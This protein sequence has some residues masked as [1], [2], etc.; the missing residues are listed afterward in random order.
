VRDEAREQLREVRAVLGREHG[1]GDGETLGTVNYLGEVSG[2][3][4]NPYGEASSPLNVDRARMSVDASVVGGELVVDV[5]IRRDAAPAEDAAAFTET[6]RDALTGYADRSERTGLRPVPADYGLDTVTLAQLDALLGD[7]RA[8][9]V[10]P[11]SPLQEGML[12]E[13]MRGAG[14][15]VVQVEYAFAAAT[16]ADRL[17]RAF[18]E[19]SART[20]ALRSVF[21]WDAGTAP[22]QL[23]L[24][25]TGVEFRHSDHRA[26]SEE[27]RRAALERR[28]AEQHARPFDLRRGPLFRCDAFTHADDAHVLVFTHHHAVLDGWSLSELC[29]RF[30]AIHDALA[31]GAPMPDGETDG[32]PIPTHGAHARL[33]AE[34][35]SG[36]F[37]AYWSRLL[38]GHEGGAEITGI[39]AGGTGTG[40]LAAASATGLATRLQAAFSARGATL[41]HVAEAAWGLVLSRLTGT[42]DVVFGKVVSGRDVALPGV[43]RTVGLFI[44]TVPARV[45]LDP[46]AT[47]AGLVDAVREQAV[48]TAEHDHGSLARIQSIAGVEDLVRCVFAVENYHVAEDAVLEFRCAREATNYPLTVTVERVG[49]EVEV[50]VLHDR[51]VLGAGD[52][53]RIAGRFLAVLE[54]FAGDAERPLSEVSGFLAGERERV[55]DVFDPSRVGYPRDGW[56]GGVFA[57]VA[58]EHADRVALVHGGE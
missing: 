37:D 44:N 25:D 42:P 48:A 26:L 13:H 51:A 14:D 23:V 43:E 28:C 24:P 3:G 8:D 20:P 29:R 16:D 7:T 40:R 52:A 39:E 56:I 11:L 34:R 45:R 2:P 10:H 35:G 58:A 38:D 30:A 12:Y 18:A 47:A 4:L 15:H 21:A 32:G 27:D 22:H 50:T 19:L 36:D 9:A 17:S 54:E 55:L 31:S 6:V 33:L 46:G 53:E 49:D 5:A 41:A 1:D 57:G